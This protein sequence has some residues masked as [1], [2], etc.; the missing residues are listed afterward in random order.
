MFKC[1]N[2]WSVALS[3]ISDTLYRIGHTGQ[4][5]GPELATSQRTIGDLSGVFENEAARQAM[6]ADR[7]VYRV[8]ACMP[9][10]DGT[11]GGLYFG[12][13]FIESGRVGD[14]YFMTRGHWH[15]KIDTAE[16]YWGI[17]GEGVLIL[18]D[19]ARRCWAERVVPGSL[20]YI[21]GRVAHRLANVGDQ[22]LAVGACWGSEAGHDYAAIERDGFSA[23][24]KSIDG[25]PTLVEAC[26]S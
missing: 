5:E 25:A 11:P 6:S 13:S 24:L 12:T 14:E 19:E 16:Y 10:P 17:A 18:M 7:V 21:P 23:R 8:T 4:L 2:I 20:H 15:R 3:A 9:V 26:T 22:M 1:S